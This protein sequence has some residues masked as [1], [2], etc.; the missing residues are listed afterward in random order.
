MSLLSNGHR[1]CFPEGE[2]DHSLRSSAE[3]KNEWIYT[4]SPP[5]MLPWC[6]QGKLYLFTSAWIGLI[7]DLCGESVSKLSTEVDGGKRN[8]FYACVENVKAETNMDTSQRAGK[9]FKWIWALFP[10]RSYQYCCTVEENLADGSGLRIFLSSASHWENKATRWA[11]FALSACSSS[12]TYVIH[13][14]K[15]LSK[16]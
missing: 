5:Y 1:R 4:S 12:H 8:W 7:R 10:P 15:S 2:V 6:G 14:C 11:C 13:S 3:A 16:T 9:V